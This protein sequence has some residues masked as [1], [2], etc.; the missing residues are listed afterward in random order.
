MNYIVTGLGFGDEGKGCTVDALC[1]YA[2]A[3]TVVR[4]NGGGQAAHNVVLPDGTHHTFAQ[5]GSNSFLPGSTT[6]LSKHMIVNPMSFLVE[7]DVLLSKTSIPRVLVDERALVT[8]PYHIQLNRAREGARGVARHGTTGMGISETVK[9][10]LARPDE[11]LRCGDL[12]TSKCISK[13]QA[14]YDYLMVE[15]DRFGARS[16]FLRVDMNLVLKLFQ[17]FSE[18]VAICQPDQIKAALQLAKGVVFEGA[19][20][21]L[22]DQDYGFH[23]HTTWSKTTS[24]NAMEL[25]DENE[26]E[27]PLRV[28]V[29][30]TYHTRHGEG[31][32]P[33]EQ[34]SMN[35]P[36]LH[37]GESGYAGQFRTG[38]LD[39]SLLKYAVDCNAGID[40]LSV[41]HADYRQR[42]YCLDNG[43]TLDVPA[44]RLEQEG[45]TRQAWHL[46]TEYAGVPDRWPEVIAEL[47]STEL[48][49]V[50][51]GPT[52]KDKTIWK[53]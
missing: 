52:Y 3:D 6:V 11:V 31:P 19:Q 42:A 18:E 1:R 39:V 34:F 38:F 45:L 28:G 26:L 24:V 13:L 44:G 29:T 8:T 23:P 27:K 41:N 9:D 46:A 25:A 50:G 14:T 5:F 17:V 36:E 49:L 20:G 15:M 33:T 37:N 4:H 10:A 30:R 21:V 12:R 7:R 35:L 40:R 16:N 43:M 53:H 22:L 51:S 2:G 32:F 48:I 47:L